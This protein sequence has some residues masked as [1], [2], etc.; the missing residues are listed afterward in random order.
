MSCVLLDEVSQ[1]GP[2]RVTKCPGWE[3]EHPH[4]LRATH[5]LPPYPDI[6]MSNSRD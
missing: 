5:V 1:A 6:L 3:A 4:H 2:T